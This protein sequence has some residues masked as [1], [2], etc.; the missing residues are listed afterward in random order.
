MSGTI[1]ISLTWSF[2]SWL[3]AGLWVAATNA[4]LIGDLTTL[5]WLPRLNKKE[6]MLNPRPMTLI[7]AIAAILTVIAHWFVWKENNGWTGALAPLLIGFIFLVSTMV[8]HAI[9]YWFHQ[10]M[11]S[12]WITIVMAALAITTTIWFWVLDVTPG[13]LML[14]VMVWVFY[15]SLWNYQLVRL[16][17]SSSGRVRQEGMGK[18][19]LQQDGESVPPPE[20]WDQAGRRCP[21]IRPVQKFRSGSRTKRGP[22][23]VRPGDAVDIFTTDNN[24]QRQRNQRPP[25]NK[26]NSDLEMHYEDLSDHGNSITFA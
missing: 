5:Y 4:W 24:S 19:V 16:N 9:F 3:F 1:E 20:T 2:F 21:Y 13:V 12:F 22:V 14:F 25:Q 18:L 15:V 11:T 26:V 7:W 23:Y 6:W 8:W 17:T 10:I